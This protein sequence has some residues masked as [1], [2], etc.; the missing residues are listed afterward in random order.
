MGKVDSFEVS[1]I[2]LFFI[3]G[4]HWPPHFHARRPDEWEIR[5]LFMTCTEK[6]LDFQLKWPRNGEG[7]SG[8]DQRE[9]RALALAHRAALLEQWERMRPK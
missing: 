5:V 4:D 9:I 1:G 3:P 2:E 7:P 8:S 6:T